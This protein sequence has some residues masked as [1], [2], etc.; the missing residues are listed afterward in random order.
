MTDKPQSEGCAE[1][2]GPKNLSPRQ[3]QFAER[4]AFLDGAKYDGEKLMAKVRKKAEAGF[5]A[6]TAAFRVLKPKTIL[7]IE[8]MKSVHHEGLCMIESCSPGG[9]FLDWN[10]GPTPKYIVE[11]RAELPFITLSTPLYEKSVEE[12]LAMEAPIDKLIEDLLI[13]PLSNMLDGHFISLLRGSCKYTGYSYSYPG[14][15][16]E[17]SAFRVAGDFLASGHRQ[18]ASILMPSTGFNR[19]VSEIEH[20]DLYRGDGHNTV[21][22]KTLIVSNK[23]DLFSS[24]PYGGKLDQ[25]HHYAYDEAYPV[26]AN[27]GGCFVNGEARLGKYPFIHLV[28]GKYEEN[29][30]FLHGADATSKTTNAWR[31]NE[32]YAL[33]DGKELGKCYRLGPVEVDVSVTGRLLRMEARTT[34]AIGVIDTSGVAMAIRV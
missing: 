19:L 4:V 7:P 11:P 29:G 23:S 28:N 32:M 13:S 9:Y 24:N 22:G 21:F 17:K 26:G 16:P 34:I 1:P 18:M 14:N 8:A 20:G 6:Q 5:V 31:G 33:V 25:A 12:F 2:I 10:K 27:I 3:A 30:P 15:L